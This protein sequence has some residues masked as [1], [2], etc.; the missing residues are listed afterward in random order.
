MA[1][2]AELEQLMYL[3][4]YSQHV[5]CG[6]V[7]CIPRKCYINVEQKQSS[8]EGRFIAQKNGV[9]FGRKPSLSDKQVIELIAEIEQAEIP[10]A[11]IAK[12]YGI[13]KTTLYRVCGEATV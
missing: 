8:Q 7:K 13:S 1:P 3:V 5:V 2:R 10:K 4:G 9:K 11:E 12:R 6:G